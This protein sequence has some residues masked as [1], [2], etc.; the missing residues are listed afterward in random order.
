MYR[1]VRFGFKAANNSAKAAII[2]AS[3]ESVEW[4][5][6]GRAFMA[7]ERAVYEQFNAQAV[8]AEQQQLIAYLRSL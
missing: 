5:E 8:T 1:Q 6:R 7:A 3:I 2:Q 4:E